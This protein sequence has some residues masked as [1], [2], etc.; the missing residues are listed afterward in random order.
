MPEFLARYDD[1]NVEL[2]DGVVRERSED[3]T[4]Y[5]HN[6][7]LMAIAMWFRQHAREWH[8]GV[9]VTQNVL[10]DE[11]NRLVPDVVIFDPRNPREQ[12]FTHPPIAVFEVTSE[13]D[14]PQDIT[15]KLAKYECWG[16]P[17]IWQVYPESGEFR[18]W[19]HGSL[20]AQERFTH[21]TMD[22]AVGEIAAL[23]LDWGE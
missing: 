8:I 12:S 19:Q 7:W 4:K 9:A 14:Q 13:S 11:R 23:L 15:N 21:G 2:I 6:D 16:V 5:D 10:I 1:T 20:T 18:R 3:V 17:E 22:F